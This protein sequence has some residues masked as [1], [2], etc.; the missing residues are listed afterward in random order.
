[1]KL[2]NLTKRRLCT[3]ITAAGAAVLIPTIALAVSGCSVWPG[4]SA[5]SSGGAPSSS[6]HAA[7][8][9]A[10]SRVRTVSAN[11]AASAGGN[12]ASGA[13]S[14]GADTTCPANFLTDW[15]GL[16]GD[17]SAGSTE[18]MAE[19]SNTSGTTCTL[20]GFPG[21]SAIGAG[22]KQLGSPA[23]R[24][25]GWTELPIT[26]RPFQT[27]HFVLRIAD[28]GNFPPASCHPTTAYQ[29]RIYAPGDYQS[30]LIG[31]TFQAC[32]K[33]GPVFLQVSTMLQ[34]TGIP[35]VGD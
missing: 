16:P 8:R 14:S 5:A 30:K 20:Y 12:A 22:G 27:A 6:H 31:F 3:A 35:G 19:I 17:A 2:T 32:A 29:L 33:P 1:M 28:A 7:A 25:N 24:S 26:L 9:H 34:G 13:G 18:Y 21:V 15:Y 23:I 11:G 10:R 4:S